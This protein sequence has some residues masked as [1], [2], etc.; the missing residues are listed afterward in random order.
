MKLRVF[1]SDKGDCL[2][3]AGRNNGKILCDGGMQESFNEF[4][5][6]Q[7]AKE[8]ALDLVY[9]SH[10]DDDHIAGILKLLDDAWTWRI[11]E[12]HKEQGDEDVREPKVPKPPEIKRIW[13]NAFRTQVDNADEVEDLL[14][15]MVPILSQVDDVALQQAAAE[16]FSIVNSNTQAIRV[17]QRVGAEQLGIPLNENQKL[18]MIRKG[19][20]PFKFGDLSVNVIAPFAEDVQKFRDEWNKWLKT[21]KDKVKELKD[22]ARRDA[23]E[24]DSELGR[25]LM[26]LVTNAKELGDR[27]A[28]TPPN[29]A[30]IMLFVEDGQRTALMT[31][32]GHANDVIKGLES[33]GRLAENGTLHVDVLKVQHHGSEHNMTE[34]FAHRITADHY[35]FCGNGFSGNP[36]PVVIDA[37]FK[38]RV[39]DGAGPNKKF[40]FWFN[41]SKAMASG[42][43][44]RARHMGQIERQVAGLAEQSSRLDSFFLEDGDHFD[45]NLR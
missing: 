26:P 18:I 22:K 24:L 5:A 37:L 15:A 3:L 9:V 17:S 39:E 38:A 32:D 16:N 25:L 42:K 21:N 43:A 45:I 29:L 7:L 13:H 12:H 4:V 35:V 1:P 41:S 27:D 40:K 20:P 6:A 44:D 30:S 14:A 8:D 19:Q 23:R 31:G 11:F 33:I 34:E 10:V 36:E 2:L 28:V